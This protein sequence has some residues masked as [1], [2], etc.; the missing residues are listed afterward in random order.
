MTS[1]ENVGQQFALYY[2]MTHRRAMVGL[3]ENPDNLKGLFVHK[4]SAVL[5]YGHHGVIIRG[6]QSPDF[7]KDAHQDSNWSVPGLKPHEVKNMV[8]ADPH[9]WTVVGAVI[10]KFTDPEGKVRHDEDDELYDRRGQLLPGTKIEH[11]DD[12]GRPVPTQEY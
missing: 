7:E 6:P 4:D 8:I 3:L 2:H 10:P 5:E 9:N 12:S 1:P 11:N